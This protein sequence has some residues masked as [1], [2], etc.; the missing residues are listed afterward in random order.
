MMIIGTSWT[1]YEAY[2]Y[3]EYPG[4]VPPSFARSANLNMQSCFNSFHSNLDLRMSLKCKRLTSATQSIA[5]G[6]VN[7]H[8]IAITAWCQ[9]IMRANSQGQ[10]HL[11]FKSLRGVLEI[12]A[13]LV[14]EK[15]VY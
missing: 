8:C 2:G 15:G 1:S 11:M 6:S 10:K 12:K 14:T 5:N 3:G 13:I 9:G 4:K 7:G